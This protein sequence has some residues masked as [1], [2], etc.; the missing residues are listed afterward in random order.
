MN[1]QSNYDGLHDLTFPAIFL[2]GAIATVNL[3]LKS[4]FVFIVINNKQLIMMTVKKLSFSDRFR[5]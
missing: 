5:T 1:K 2:K 4:D 3:V